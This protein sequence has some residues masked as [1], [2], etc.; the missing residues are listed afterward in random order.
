MYKRV[1]LLHGFN[2]KDG[3]AAT[4]DRLRPMLEQAG[5]KV[6][7]FDY[8]FLDLMMVRFRTNFI[9]KMLKQFSDKDDRVI[10]H[11]HG[12]AITAK[13]MEQ[14]AMFDKCVFIHPALYSKW[15]IPEKDSAR[16]ITVY[17]SGK[18]IATWAARLLRKY[19]PLKRLFKE[20]FWG[21]MGSTGPVSTDKRWNSINDGHSHSGI[22]K[23]LTTWE[24]SIL[25]ALK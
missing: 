24:Q 20:H 7:E 18:D 11:S 6:E 16:K 2:V 4:V 13:A 25:D 14:G 5:Y 9:A 10:A 17:F 8:G 12:C 19:S 21:A 15:Q 3:G 23:D 1:F 22:F